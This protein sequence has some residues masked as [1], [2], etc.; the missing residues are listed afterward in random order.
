M[1][2]ETYLYVKRDLFVWKKR[3]ICMAKEHIHTL[4]PTPGVSPTPYTLHPTLYTLYPP[5]KTQKHKN[6]KQNSARLESAQGKGKKNLNKKKDSGRLEALSE[7]KAKEKNKKNK[8]NS[9]RL[10][11]LS[12]R[13]AKVLLVVDAVNELDSGRTLAWL[14]RRLPPTVQAHTH[15]HTHT[16]TCT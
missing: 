13:K 1:A 2:K 7:R 12:E 11:A 8:K 15:T 14:P 9:G 5:K 16:H 10:E 4:H 3:P 6:T